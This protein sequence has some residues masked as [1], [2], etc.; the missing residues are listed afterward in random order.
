MAKQY[1][2]AELV[3]KA[4]VVFNAYI[5]ERDKGLKCISC[6]KGAVENAGHYIAVGG[7]SVH[8]FNE[9]NVHGQCIHCNHFKGSNAINYRI[10]LVKKI[11][12][13]KVELLEG[14]MRNPKKWS[15]VELLA[16]IQHYK[17]K[18]K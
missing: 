4:Q 9:D 11:G 2:Q 6:Q 14:T 8:R 7:H 17:T 10:N 13:D 5:R 18:L 1:T 3:K 12:V 15:R 16:I